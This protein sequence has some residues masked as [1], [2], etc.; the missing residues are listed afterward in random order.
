M[1]THIVQ[2]ERQRFVCGL[3]W[4]SLSRRHEL[5]KEG[6]ELAK[7]LNFELMVL[8]IDR[9][10]AA[11]G[12]ANTREGAQAGVPSLGVI[13]SKTI[14]LEGAFYDGRQ[15]SAPN[16]LGAF[17]LPDGRW[18]YFAVRDGSF[19]PNGDWVGS[20]DEVFER[21]NSDYGLG[22]WNV[23][24]GD[25]EIEGMGFHNF[26]PRRIEELL[27]KRRAGRMHVPNWA[28]LRPVARRLSWR[29]IGLAAGVLACA[30]LAVSGVLVHRRHTL[31]AERARLLDA[32]RERLAHTAATRSDDDAR[33]W[34]VMPA[35][36]QLARVCLDH[37]TKLA[38]GGWELER[39]VCQPRSIDYLW[40]RNGSTAALLLA[41]EPLAQLDNTGERASLSQ[42]LH[43]TAGDDE[44]LL[45]RASVISRL[46]TRFQLLE[47]PLSLAPLPEN[48]P[49]GGLAQLGQRSPPPRSWHAWRLQLNL[50]AM[51]PGMLKRYLDEPGVRLDKLTYQAGT[52]SAQG[53]VY[54]K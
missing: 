10:V 11:A 20:S 32:A 29:A 28:R 51:P 34:A 24:I 6:V 12:F 45:M 8:R 40:S 44:P 14:A 52:W 39:F 4:Q 18:A 49:P 50:G 33:P 31:E 7:K 22:G 17:K 25:S 16:W 27:G 43:M 38:P 41:R 5:R 47:I 36:S 37:F 35:P 42:P 1:A 19:L 53:V 2:I 23:V 48:Q 3:F 26:Y 9:G 46:L 30:A 15:Q 54:A 21:L 13:V